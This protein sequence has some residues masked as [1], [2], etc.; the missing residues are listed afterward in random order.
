MPNYNRY[1][2]RGIKVCK[3]WEK[4]DDGMS[5]FECFMADMGNK[6]S[7]KHS[8]DRINND[9]DYEPANC[10]WATNSEQANNR[11]SNRRLTYNGKTL[12]MLKMAELHGISYYALRDRI[13]RGWSVSEAIELNVDCS[14]W[15]R[16][17]VTPAKGSQLPQAK[18]TEESVKQLRQDYKNKLGD[19]Y[20]LAEQ[21]HVSVA[22]VCL[23]I[24]YKTWKHVC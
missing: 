1:G 16:D 11:S 19:M 10:K 21:Y 14:G 12:S 4:G 13:M 20:E 24:N 17:S 6:P 8:L 3:R 5:G 2:G 15:K 9:G 22:A 18:L 23:A 7:A